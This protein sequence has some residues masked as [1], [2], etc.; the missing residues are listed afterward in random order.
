MADIEKVEDIKQQIRLDK[1]Q[2]KE[3]FYNLLRP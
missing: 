3:G 1:K 2:I